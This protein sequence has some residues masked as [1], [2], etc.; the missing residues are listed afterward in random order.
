[1]EGISISERIEPEEMESIIS[2]KMKEKGENEDGQ[3]KGA[4]RAGRKEERNK[5]D[6][7][8]GFD[9]NRDI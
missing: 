4:K 7:K 3:D 9:W 6:L 2:V 8:A 5:E 1:M